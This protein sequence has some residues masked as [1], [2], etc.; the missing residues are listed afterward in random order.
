MVDVQWVPIP[1][2]EDK[3]QISEAGDIRT[4]PRDIIDSD[5][6]VITSLKSTPINIYRPGDSTPYAILHD[7]QKYNKVTLQILLNSA[8]SK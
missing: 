8:F 3:Y 4:K 5:G 6:T 1:G 7:G 2:Y